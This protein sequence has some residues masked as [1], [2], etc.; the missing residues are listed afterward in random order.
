MIFV[1]E[2]NGRWFDSFD[3]E[4]QLRCHRHFGNEQQLG[5]PAR[6]FNCLR[7]WAFVLTTWKVENHE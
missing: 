5:F 7:R 6:A 2:G 1:V 3:S 4:N